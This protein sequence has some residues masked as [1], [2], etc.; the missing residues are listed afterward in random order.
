MPFEKGDEEGERRQSAFQNGL[1]QLGWTNGQ[2]VRIEYRWAGSNRDRIRDAAVELVGLRPDVI[3]ASSALTLTPLQRQTSIIPIVFTNIA[4]PVSSGFVASLAHPGG[5]ITGFSPAEFSMYGKLLGILKEAVPNLTRVAVIMNPEQAP[6][7]GMMRAIEAAAPT[8]AVKTSSFSVRDPLERSLASFAQEG[9]GGLI[10]LP[11]PVVDENREL[12]ARMAVRHGLPTIYTFRY[13]V[14]SGG[15]M[16]YG[17]DTVDHLQKAASYVDRILKGTKP[18]DLPV[19]EP[20]KFELVINLKTVLRRPVESAAISRHSALQQRLALFDH[21]VGGG[22][23]GLRECQAQCLSRLE[24]NDKIKL[25]GLFD[26]QIRWLRALQYLVHVCRTTPKEV[27]VAWAIGHQTA[28]KYVLANCEHRGNSVAFKKVDDLG[29]LQ[30][31]ECVA[32]RHQ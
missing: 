23:Q 4:D 9:N 8:L 26:R 13:Y 14:T 28:C 21:L 2:N 16:S 29:D 10:V 20:T 5:N 27:G 15:L 30:I 7:A 25:C 18:A 17:I 6:Q 3:L 31:E 11:N 19:E 1:E 32:S 24:I 22:D 12:I